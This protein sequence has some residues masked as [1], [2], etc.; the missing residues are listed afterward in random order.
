M[1][2]GRVE[3]SIDNA[4][5]RCSLS[6]EVFRGSSADSRRTRGMID[7]TEDHH[8]WRLAARQQEHALDQPHLFFVH[9]GI[10]V[11]RWAIRGKRHMPGGMCHFRG[12]ADRLEKV[13]LSFGAHK[14]LE[15]LAH[16]TLVL[17]SR[18]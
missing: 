13:R 9:R 17:S 15:I 14:N 1:Q 7:R 8:A 12:N 5:L 16:T 11:Y 18:A 6:G 2:R 3:V 10:D 4:Y